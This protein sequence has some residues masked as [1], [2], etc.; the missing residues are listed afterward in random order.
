M[1]DRIESVDWSGS[2]CVQHRLRPIKGDCSRVLLACVCVSVR[3][4][5]ERVRV[6]YL[7]VLLPLFLLWGL[8]GPAIGGP[9]VGD[10]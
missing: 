5:A 10:P 3:G 8:H 2:T 1:Q 6:D 9:V 4:E 7:L